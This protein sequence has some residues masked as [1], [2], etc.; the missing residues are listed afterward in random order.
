MKNHN[1]TRLFAQ[2]LFDLVEQKVFKSVN[3]HCLKSSNFW[4]MLFVECLFSDVF[5]TETLCLAEDPQIAAA[6]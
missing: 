3:M 1:K 4:F 6:L 5:K 2:L